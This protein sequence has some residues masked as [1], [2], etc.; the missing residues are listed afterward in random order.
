M[1]G[2][3]TVGLAATDAGHGARARE[4]WGAGHNCDAQLDFGNVACQLVQNSC[5]GKRPAWIFGGFCPSPDGR[6]SGRAFVERVLRRVRV[7]GMPRLRA[8]SA[9]T[10]HSAG[11]K[12]HLLD[13][14]ERDLRCGL[15]ETLGYDVR[16]VAYG[17]GIDPAASEAA[18]DTCKV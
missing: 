5:R 11:S 6:G 3:A 16:T 15:Q 14:T 4:A 2:R 9:G 1:P 17:G 10:K 18:E 7:R 13:L 8:G 12:L